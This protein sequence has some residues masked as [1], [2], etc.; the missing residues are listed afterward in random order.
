MN[1]RESRGITHAD[2]P[3]GETL[4]TSGRELP[5]GSV[6]SLSVSAASAEQPIIPADRDTDLVVP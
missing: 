2:P 6:T 4:G 3:I 5:K 1:Y